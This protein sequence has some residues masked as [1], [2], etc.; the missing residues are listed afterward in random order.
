[1]GTKLITNLSGR[2]RRQIAR[3]PTTVVLPRSAM[4]SR[5]L[6]GFSQ[7]LRSQVKYSG[8]GRASQQKRLAHVRFGSLADILG[9]MKERP[10]YP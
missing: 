6:M 2:K 10:L 7:R 5:C 4:N 1:M 9:C 3:G 8:S